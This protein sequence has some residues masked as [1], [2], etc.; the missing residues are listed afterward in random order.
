[1]KTIKRKTIEVR[2]LIC[3]KNYLIEHAMDNIG[4]SFRAVVTWIEPPTVVN[5]PWII[6]FD[7]NLVL[8]VRDTSLIVVIEGL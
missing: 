1:M 2:D 7:N 8:R 3:G 5:M 4:F 6:H